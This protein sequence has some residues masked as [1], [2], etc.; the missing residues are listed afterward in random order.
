MTTIREPRHDGVAALVGR[1]TTAAPSRPLRRRRF[2]LHHQPSDTRSPHVVRLTDRSLPETF[3]KRARSPSRCSPCPRAP[4]GLRRPYRREALTE[5]ARSRAVRRRNR[6]RCEGSAHHAELDGLPASDKGKFPSSLLTRLPGMRLYTRSSKIWRF[7]D[8]RLA[9]STPQ[10][11]PPACDGG[12][13]SSLARRHVP[14]RRQYFS[15]MAPRRNDAVV[16]RPTTIRSGAAAG[17]RS[18]VLREPASR[19]AMGGTPGWPR[20]IP[21]PKLPPPD[22]S[23]PGATSVA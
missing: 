22:D 8:R 2:E 23:L 3:R 4:A 18:L 16:T 7:P 1:R 21:L 6:L 12:V 10:A 5:S 17:G 13:V 19:A 15:R 20:S 9:W 14:F 11:P